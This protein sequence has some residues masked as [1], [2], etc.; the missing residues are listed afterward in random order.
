[1]TLTSPNVSEVITFIWKWGADCL[2]IPERR[3]SF[4]VIALILMEARQDF[5]VNMSQN[6]TGHLIVMA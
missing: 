5:E 2:S 1:M 3:H 6:G 4:Q